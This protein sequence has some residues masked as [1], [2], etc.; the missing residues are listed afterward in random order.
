MIAP[1]STNTWGNASGQR[2]H[3]QACGSGGRA[4]GGELLGVQPETAVAA[5]CRWAWVSRLRQGSTRRGTCFIRSRPTERYVDTSIQPGD[6]GWGATVELQ[7]YYHLTGGLY[8]YGNA[9][10]LFN[11]KERVLTTGFPYPTPTWRGAGSTFMWR[12]CAAWPSALVGAS[13]V[14][15]AMMRS[16]AAAAAAD[17]AL[18][19]RL[20]PA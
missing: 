9:F 20:N 8:T 18:P 16:A 4:P 19:W 14:C 10:Y 1:P 13:K 12:V 3:T 15:R 6:G 7:G 11:P 17:R 5:M 2:F